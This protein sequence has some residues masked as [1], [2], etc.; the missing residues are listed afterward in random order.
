MVSALLFFILPAAG[1]ML[2]PAQFENCE[3]P[4][5][6]LEGPHLLFHYPGVRLEFQPIGARQILEQLAA[7]EPMAR[8]LAN[9]ITLSRLE[10]I[11][12]FVVKGHNEG[13]EPFHFN[14]DQVTLHWGSQTCRAL[15]PLHFTFGRDLEVNADLENFAA[16]F[17]TSNWTL[18]PGEQ[19]EQWLAFQLPEKRRSRRGSLSAREIYYGMESFQFSARLKLP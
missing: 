18:E 12:F 2:G 13:R 7:E 6:S 11:L 19:E 8:A 14:P 16:R 15:T 10:G 4:F 9:P 17:I 3:G 5:V 1:S